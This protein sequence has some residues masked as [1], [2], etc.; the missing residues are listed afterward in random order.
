MLE[1]HR[2]S[3]RITQPVIT[4]SSSSSAC[5]S[6]LRN[7]FYQ[8]MARC[9]LLTML[10]NKFGKPVD[11]REAIFRPF[12]GLSTAILTDLFTLSLSR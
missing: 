4:T 2:D 6:T 9:C 10:Q 1:M 8:F 7:Q 12:A 3:I 11:S 5:G